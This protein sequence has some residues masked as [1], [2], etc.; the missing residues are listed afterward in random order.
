MNAK[1]LNLGR[2]KIDGVNAF[3]GGAEKKSHHTNCL[4]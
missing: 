4:V 2:M 3:G 1:G